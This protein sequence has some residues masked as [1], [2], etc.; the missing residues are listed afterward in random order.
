MK[1]EITSGSEIGKKGILVEN[2]H[3]GWV[4]LTVKLSSTPQVFS[5]VNIPKGIEHCILGWKRSKQMSHQ[6]TQAG[7][8]FDLI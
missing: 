7:V 5:S 3:P 1:E 2:Q 6:K 8:G 4:A